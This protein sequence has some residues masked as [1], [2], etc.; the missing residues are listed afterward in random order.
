MTKTDK[1]TDKLIRQALT[2]CCEQ[3]K[4]EIT[5]FSWLTHQVNYADFPNSLV[6]TC[7]FETQEQLIAAQHKGDKNQLQTI[8]INQL[9]KL[10]IKLK[11]TNRQV[12]FKGL[13][14]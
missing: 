13:A 11:Q 4:D 5:G 3:A 8:I 2:Q 1:K 9:T 7:M 6:V 10:G 14:G 12:I